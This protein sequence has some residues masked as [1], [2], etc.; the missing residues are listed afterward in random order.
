M[1]DSEVV[2]DDIDIDSPEEEED[3]RKRR[4]WIVLAVIAL[5]LLLLFCCVTAS[6]IWYLGSSEQARFVARNLECLQCHTELIPAFSS[7][8]VHDPF[9]KKECLTCHTPHGKNVAVTVTRGPAEYLTRVSTVIRWLPL[10]WWLSL[11]G[12]VSGGTA[13]NG[14]NG[15][16]SVS[17]VKGGTAGLVV[18]ETELCWTC[19]GSMGKKLGDEFQHTPFA[20]GRCGECHD[21]HA[22]KQP[23][24]L[25]QAP[26]QL[27][28]TCHP[29]GMEI[30]REQSHPPAAAGWCIDCHD[31]HAS[32]FEGIIVARQRELCFRCHPT[33][34]VLS[35]MAVQ[36]A[37]FLNDDCTGCHQPHGSDYVPLL[38]AVQPDLCYQCHPAIEDQFSRP[39]H[40]PVGVKLECGSCHDPHA[41]QYRGL[42]NA[43]GN[44]F[45]YRCHGRMQAGFA[46][47]QHSGR[48]CVNCHTPHGST[49]DPILVQRNPD[50]CFQCHDSL[51]YNENTKQTHRNNHPVQPNWYDV[52]AEAPLT[53]TSSC[54]NPH[55]T[56]KNHMLRYFSS[57][58]DGNCL[59]CH[60]VTRGSRVGIDY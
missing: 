52:N 36:H 39:S 18:P 60:A 44:Q 49:C 41:T 20:T 2:Q 43:Q 55:E 51:D 33:V 53:C 8:S 28:F 26:D 7:V 30:N 54:H 9:A 31:P 21:P 16:S 22:S 42:V 32:R 15:A 59:M 23:T 19:H 17:K 24:L 37:P 1:T 56:D 10:R 57:P 34:A 40:H 14:S 29:M 47:S 5:L 12:A 38:N 45:C 11:A 46:D 6:Q 13:E 4:R 27:C 3:E 25:V 35:G 58:F 50:L 48:L